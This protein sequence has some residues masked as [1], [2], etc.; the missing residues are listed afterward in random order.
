[1]L[2]NNHSLKLLLDSFDWQI[3]YQLR[4]VNELLSKLTD[5]NAALSVWT[6]TSACAR[7]R[8]EQWTSK[9]KSVLTSKLA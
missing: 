2:N 6:V 1:V 4:I 5:T 3:K 9:E 7:M 8:Y